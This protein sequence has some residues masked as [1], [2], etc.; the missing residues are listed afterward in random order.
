[1]KL[2]QEILDWIDSQNQ[3]MADLVKSWSD[4]NTHTLNVEGIQIFSDLL[5]KEM[6]KRFPGRFPESNSL[7]QHFSYGSE[8]N[9][10]DQTL[11]SDSKRDTSTQERETILHIDEMLSLEKIFL[12]AYPHVQNNGEVVEREMGP[13]LSFK[14]MSS[15]KLKILFQIHMDTVYP[16]DSS[17]Q[18]ADWIDANT[19]CGPGVSDA[20]GGIAIIF[21]LME[22]IEKSPWADEISWEIFLNS[23]EE[24]GSPVSREVMR[25]K[26]KEFDWALV[27]EPSLPDGSLIGGRKGSG[28]FTLRIRGLSAHAGREFF[29]GANALH[30][31]AE[32]IQEMTTWNQP[33]SGVTFNTGKIDGGGP[34]NVVA[35]LAVVRF[36]IRISDQKKMEEVQEHMEQLVTKIKSR[37]N[38]DAELYGSFYSPP[39]ELSGKNL[40]LM[41]KVISCGRKL[42]LNL[43][44]QTSGGVCDGNK[45]SAF[46]LANVDTLGPRG[47]DIHSHNE[48]LF[49]DSL[50][51]RCKL[52]YLL[53]QNL[54][55]EVS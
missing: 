20:K 46:G 36:N 50:S 28:N 14:K 16:R 32:F 31:A 43:K 23:D 40:L 30:A 48:T 12:P 41:E 13:C 51:E 9:K 8:T 39:K 11:L 49:T 54:L 38:L 45:L 55:E 35:D 33:E 25:D 47:K 53:I 44:Y 7:H 42:G 34:V 37:E 2:N 5:I 21:T 22:A 18:K 17:F 52:S 4:I 26:A 24:I 10:A 29:Q 27:F 1:M 6:H 19:L 15:K 3:K